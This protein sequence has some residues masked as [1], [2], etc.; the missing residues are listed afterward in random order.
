MDRR[1]V[2]EP[3]SD[4]TA[5]MM[6][7]PQSKSRNKYLIVFENLFTR[8]VEVKPVP[9]ATGVVVQEALKDLEV[10]RW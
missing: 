10:F 8:W 6:E 9:N 4:S 7:F 3:W 5:D 1:E 2:E